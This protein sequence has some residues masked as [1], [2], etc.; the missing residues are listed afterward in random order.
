M[1]KRIGKKEERGGREG[2]KERE[3]KQKDWSYF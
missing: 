1:K 2:H 3:C